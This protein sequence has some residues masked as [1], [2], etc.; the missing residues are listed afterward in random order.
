M[1]T[2]LPFIILGLT[3]GAVYGVAASGLVLAYRTSG[4][5]NFAH[6]STAAVAAGI[7]YWLHDEHG[8][9]W[10]FAALIAVLGLALVAGAVMERIA[11]VLARVPTTLSVAATVGLSIALTAVIVIWY[12]PAPLQFPSFLPSSTFK[13]G[14]VLVGY[15]QV[16]TVAIG[17]VAVASMSLML[18]YS[19]RGRA[20]RAIVEDPELLSL[21][22]LSGYSVRSLAWFISTAFAAI[23]GILIAPSLG[24]D[25][26]LLTLLVIQSFGA[27]AIG[28][29]SNLPM[30]FIGG[31]VIG[32]LSALSTKYS[33][34]NDWLQG[35]PQGLPFIVLFVM[36]IVLP[37]RLLV[38]LGS[39]VQERTIG[40]VT[41]G[42]AA[43]S[44]KAAVAAILLLI[45][46]SVV[47]AHLA[48][49]TL[50]AAYLII[51]LSL[52]LLVRT[53]N[54]ISLCH[55]TFAAIGALAFHHLTGSVPW[56][57]AVLISGLIVLPV[58]LLISIP[59]IRLSGVYLALATLGFG[60]LVEQ[61]FYARSFMFGDA[62]SLATPRPSFA[63]GP[64]AYY[65]LVVGFVV[66][67]YI[68]VRAIEQGRLGR[69]LR[70]RA[71]APEALTALGLN[72]R[73]T[74][75]I[76]FAISAAMAGM[77]GALIGPIFGVIG[78]STFQTVP[79][80]MLL[81]VL[82]VLGSRNRSAGTLGACMIAA[83][84]LVV[85]PDYITSGTLQSWLNVLFGA[86]AIEVAFAYRGYGLSSRIKRL[87]SPGSPI[88]P[89]QPS[90]RLSVPILIE[91]P[92]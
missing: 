1:T 7:F 64:K 33:G 73:S 35:M 27:A 47:G 74:S 2:F 14:S 36:L 42:R 24:L 91:A 8:M 39:A 18:R 62:L 58:G 82:L 30:T 71:D 66:I 57:L 11:A 41:G 10:P 75:M 13:L 72:I 84:A 5:I 46:P 69:I 45:V 50:A 70:A 77:G 83:A 87:R 81:V 61:L 31:L 29:F 17:I 51:L 12:G 20:M 80:S 68:A 92:K 89:D 59:A 26:T 32:V 60:I 38:E 49:Y 76:V 43:R 85:V 15:D 40:R 63:S 28:A 90:S 44:S 22:G 4:V 56:V 34:T 67:T 88:A 25:G 21:T 54:Q 52:S 3:S 6:G 9:A 65:Y 79:T 16:I 48:V 53:S 86:G 23:S 78:Q 55:M 37:R 19:Q